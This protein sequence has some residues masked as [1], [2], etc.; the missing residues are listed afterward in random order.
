FFINFYKNCLEIAS[1]S[2]LVIK[3]EE[4]LDALE[5]LRNVISNK[6]EEVQNVGSDVEK[7]ESHSFNDLIEQFSSNLE[8]LIERYDLLIDFKA[9]IKN[10]IKESLL[11][12]KSELRFVENDSNPEQ[13]QS[14]A[15]SPSLNTKEALIDFLD[16]KSKHFCK[17]NAV[18]SDS[19]HEM[20]DLL[21]NFDSS[22]FG[23]DPHEDLV[24]KNDIIFEFKAN[25]ISDKIKGL[26][27]GK[28]EENT[29]FLT[30]LI[31]NVSK[32]CHEFQLFEKSYEDFC[33]FSKVIETTFPFDKNEKKVKICNA[34]LKFYLIK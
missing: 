3:S 28:I 12:S 31:E 5:R 25:N 27:L 8:D 4:F 18:K 24:I 19:L 21:L 30:E 17:E 15:N 34:K 14:E 7:N 23:K 22:D 32:V 13:T 29:Q 10:V 1:N 33:K 16:H 2:S 6:S 9:S 26:A 20:A 11:F